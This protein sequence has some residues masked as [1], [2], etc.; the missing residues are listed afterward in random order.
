MPWRSYGE[1]FMGMTNDLSWFRV[2]QGR[3]L[4]Y[5]TAGERECV[6]DSTILDRG[7]STLVMGRCRTIN[8]N[9]KCRDVEFGWSAL[10]HPQSGKK[11]KCG[12]CMRQWRRTHVKIKLLCLL[13]FRFSTD[14]YLVLKTVWSVTAK[15]RSSKRDPAEYPPSPKTTSSFQNPA[16]IKHVEFFEKLTPTHPIT[17]CFLHQCC[18]EKTQ[19]Q[20]SAVPRKPIFPHSLCVF[21][22]RVSLASF[23][24]S[25]RRCNTHYCA[26]D[27]HARR[28]CIL[29]KFVL[30]PFYLSW[31]DDLSWCLSWFDK[32][33][34]FEEVGWRK[35]FLLLL[36]DKIQSSHLIWSA[37]R[38]RSANG[39]DII[40]PIKFSIFA[41][42]AKILIWTFG[43]PWKDI[44]LFPWATHGR[45][46]I[47]SGLPCSSSCAHGLVLSV[48]RVEFSI[49]VTGPIYSRRNPKSLMNILIRWPTD[50]N[51]NMRSPVLSASFESF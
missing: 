34:W 24:P 18:H 51:S 39:S 32:L 26:E 25:S 30:Y 37:D 38:W 49:R 42:V 9:M 35:I 13:F 16:F 44:R 2:N 28:S 21:D 5:V 4:E 41:N 33:R 31:F 17:W 1:R 12:R 22:P 14:I 11:W 3:R 19:R 20:A 8:Q 48:H 45:P 10:R 47:V 43:I 23:S 27:S 36:R 15:I 29:H 7:G 46:Q 6:Y 40:F 50:S